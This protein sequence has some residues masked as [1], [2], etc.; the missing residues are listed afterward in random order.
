[1]ILF[2]L[3]LFLAFAGLC[4]TAYL[5]FCRT[6]KMRPMCTSDGTCRLVLES[7]YSRLFGIHNDIL[8]LFFYVAVLLNLALIT[9]RIGPMPVEFL[10]LNALLIGGACM[11]IILTVIQWK[12][13]KHW[14]PWCLASA[15]T[16][17]LMAGVFLVAV[18]GS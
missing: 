2:I 12:L 5:V 4:E 13:I 9:M 16:N 7:K 15:C 8:G 10:A 3:L 1:M 11:S 18:V 6:Y 14:C 17:W